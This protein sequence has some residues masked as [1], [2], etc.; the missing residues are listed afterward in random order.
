MPHVP[1][2]G[3]GKRVTGAGA[4]TEGREAS[5][6][7]SEVGARR[8]SLPLSIEE[9]GRGSRPLGRHP[10]P[11]VGSPVGERNPARNNWGY[12]AVLLPSYLMA[13]YGGRTIL[14]NRFLYYYLKAR[15]VG[16]EKLSRNFDVW[17]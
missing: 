14:E 15:L 2:T 1:D 6:Q 3:P 4:R 12:A 13:A 10:A 16:V 9:K 17:I 5:R 7:P 11:A 8:E